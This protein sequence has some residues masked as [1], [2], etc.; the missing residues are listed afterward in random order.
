MHWNEVAQSWKYID[1]IREAWE[2]DPSDLVKYPVN[3]NGPKEA[4]EL[5]EK[6]GHHWVW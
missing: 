4:F 6:N 5:L 1:A 3:T 2:K